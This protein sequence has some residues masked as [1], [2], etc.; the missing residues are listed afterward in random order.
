MKALKRI[1]ALALLFI[2]TIGLSGCTN[3]KE[4]MLEH[5]KEKYGQEFV[6]GYMA[7]ISTYPTLFC[8]PKGGDPETDR[9]WIEMTEYTDGSFSFR[10]TYFGIIIREDVEAEVLAACS[11]LP[12]PMKAYFDSGDGAYNNLFDSTKTYADLKEDEIDSGERYNHAVTIAIPF[13]GTDD[14][15]K[16]KY[17]TQIFDKIEQ[18]GY[19]GRIFVRCYPSEV[20]EKIT[21]KN[22]FELHKAEYNNFSKSIY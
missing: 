17:A 20:F 1:L 19:Y 15:E 12:L 5:L 10:D 18:N 4:I 2:L 13:D 16:E 9:V 8:Y 3:K 21:R 11:D 14:D 6:P 7:G 22:V